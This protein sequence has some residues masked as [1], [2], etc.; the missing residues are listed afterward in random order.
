MLENSS[1]MFKLTDLLEVPLID[2]P[3]ESLIFH[4]G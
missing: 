2:M 4:D 3:A 1:G